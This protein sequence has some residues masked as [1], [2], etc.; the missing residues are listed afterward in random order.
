MRCRISLMQWCSIKP[1]GKLCFP[2]PQL[3]RHWNALSSTVRAHGVKCSPLHITFFK[4]QKHRWDTLSNK[5]RTRKVVLS[6]DAQ[7]DEGLWRLISRCFSVSRWLS[8]TRKPN[9]AWGSGNSRT[10]L[11]MRC[12]NSGSISSLGE[13]LDSKVVGLV[14][15]LKEKI[16]DCQ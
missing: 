4:I 5:A 16:T 15:M 14:I 3:S 6:G 10:P 2:P 7:G 12:L 11:E 9:S 13:G 8:L 1:L